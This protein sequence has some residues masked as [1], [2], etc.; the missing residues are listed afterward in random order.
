MTHSDTIVAIATPPGRGGVGIVRVSGEALTDFGHA[1]CGR[2]LTP[3]LAQ[4]TRFLDSAQRPIDDGIALYF[5]SPASFTGEDVLELQA[6]GSPMVLQALVR[7]CIELGARHAEPGEFT[8]RAYLNGK[9]DLAQAEAVADV[10]DAATES[11]AR[12]AVRS[13]TGEFSA[14]IKTLQDTIIRLRMFVE[15]TL[16][17]PEEDVEFIEAERARDQLR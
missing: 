16:D 9:L 8:K 3:R 6:H 10:I 12:A 13:L 2:N 5:A 15:A 7:R 17:F 4:H 1:L 14:R 11:A